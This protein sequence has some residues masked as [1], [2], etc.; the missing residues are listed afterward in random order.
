MGG[1][2]ASAFA[3]HRESTTNRSSRDRAWRRVIGNGGA[4][5]HGAV[6]DNVKVD[7]RDGNWLARARRRMHVL[8]QHARDLEHRD[9]LLA[10][11]QPGEVLIRNDHALVLRIL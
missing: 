1:S 11:E 5:V 4:H 6:F 8:V 7:N 2:R 9:L 3:S 10:A